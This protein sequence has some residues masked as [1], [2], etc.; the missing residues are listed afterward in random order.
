MARTKQTK[1]KTVGPTTVAEAKRLRVTLR[2]P[3]KPRGRPRVHGATRRR[4][5]PPTPH[6]RPLKAIV[7]TLSTWLE[8]RTGAPMPTVPEDR[9]LPTVPENHPPEISS[10]RRSIPAAVEVL[11]SRTAEQVQRGVAEARAHI[12][13]R[14]LEVPPEAPAAPPPTPMTPADSDD[15]GCGWLDRVTEEQEDECIDAIL[16]G[17]FTPTA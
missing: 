12:Q 11:A 17:Q 8:G 4:H 14:L 15:E 10:L 13:R 3:S 7:P 5:R 9:P 1:R 16:A 2:L 6:R